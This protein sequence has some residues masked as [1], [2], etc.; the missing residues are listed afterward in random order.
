MVPPI[1][2]DV[3]TFNHELAEWL[4]DPFT[5]NIVPTWNYPPPTDPLG[6]CSFNPFLEVGDPQGN[7]A[8]YTDFPA[9]EVPVGG[10]TFHLQQLV[11]WQ[12]FAD[13]I[14]SS[15]FGGWYTFPDPTSLTVP[16]V[17]CQ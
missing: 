17:Y 12:W 10:V 8:T 16:A 11:L 7:G 4:N 15:G 3:S 6:T 2:A 5:N 13:Q 14:P 9:I 1:L